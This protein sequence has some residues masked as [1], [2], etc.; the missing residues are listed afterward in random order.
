[1]TGSKVQRGDLLTLAHEVSCYWGKWQ[2]R[3][4]RFAMMQWELDRNGRC[5][6][7]PLANSL[8]NRE[9]G[10]S[11]LAATSTVSLPLRSKS[12]D[13]GSTAGRGPTP[14]GAN[15]WRPRGANRQGSRSDSLTQKKARD[16]LASSLPAGGVGFGLAV[17]SHGLCALPFHL[18]STS[19]SI[20]P[21]DRLK[22]ILGKLIAGFGGAGSL[23]LGVAGLGHI[24][25]GF[26]ASGGEG[27]FFCFRHG[28]SFRILGTKAA[29]R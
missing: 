10:C 22:V 21:C 1:M 8:I 5:C 6:Y 23:G 20:T 25:L 12:S 13:S 3:F 16:G 28:L 11:G 27:D 4:C 14:G 26:I 9:T 29:F 7:S 19:Y 15:V 24:L 17:I 18:S 2:I